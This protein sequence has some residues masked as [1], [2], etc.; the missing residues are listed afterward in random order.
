[1]F[2]PLSRTGSAIRQKIY[3]YFIYK[4]SD[5]GKHQS[6]GIGLHVGKST[7]IIGSEKRNMTYRA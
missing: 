6:R 3:I 7:Y 4:M 1:M 5:Y 2:S